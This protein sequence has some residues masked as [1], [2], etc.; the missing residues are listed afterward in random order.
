MYFEAIYCPLDAPDAWKR[1]FEAK[2]SPSI[3][4]LLGLNAHISHDLPL[5]MIQV[6][7]ENPECSPENIKKDYF[8][9]NDFFRDITPVLNKDLKKT[10]QKMSSLKSSYMDR[11]SLEILMI[12]I[13][14]IR[15]DAWHDFARL[16]Q[17]EEG[18]GRD[19]QIERIK[20]KALRKT[21]L[22]EGLNPLAPE[23]G[24]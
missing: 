7:K 2:V 9:L 15:K 3:H 22:L 4:L 1:T 24:L 6:A 14:K 18:R 19:Y 17:L 12:F 21:K 23:L 20:K 16:Y 10:Y 11:L 8:H 13:K 5:S